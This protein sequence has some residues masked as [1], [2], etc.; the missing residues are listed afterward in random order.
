MASN[1]RILLALPDH[2]S[3]RVLASLLPRCGIEPIFAST[4]SETRALLC[5]E[6]IALALCGT[7][8]ADGS[9]RD[10]LREARTA[11]ESVPVIVASPVHDAH[12]YLEAM[13]LG[14]FDFV[15]APYRQHEV[16]RII[17]CALRESLKV[18]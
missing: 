12:L 11:R 4:V 3:R 15:A 2:E 14:A 17:R 6:P 7:R 10:V 1:L 18:A 8:L 16:E 9:F 13:N 5:R